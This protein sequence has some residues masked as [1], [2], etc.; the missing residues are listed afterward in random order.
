MIKGI[1]IH[2]TRGRFCKGVGPDLVCCIEPDHGRREDARASVERS[3][4]PSV[5]GVRNS[6]LFLH[7]SKPPGA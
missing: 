1:E 4:L 5:A 7:F 6:N 3:S 2:A